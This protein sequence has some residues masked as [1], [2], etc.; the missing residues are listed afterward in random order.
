[1]VSPSRSVWSDGSKTHSKKKEI[2]LES[3]VSE[4][5]GLESIVS[6]RDGLESALEG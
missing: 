4:R 5:D 2:G 3:I 6:E 1:M